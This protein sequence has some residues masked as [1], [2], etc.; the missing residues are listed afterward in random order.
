MDIF[1]YLWG[2]AAQEVE[3]QPNKFIKKREK[4]KKGNDYFMDDVGQQT[5]SWIHS[6]DFIILLLFHVVRFHFLTLF[7]GYHGNPSSSLHN[8]I[9]FNP[10]G[11]INLNPILSNSINHPVSV[12]PTFKST[13][14]SPT[15]YSIMNNY[16]SWIINNYLT[17][18]IRINS[19]N[20]NN[21]II[22]LIMDNNISLI[23]SN[24]SITFCR[25]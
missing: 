17:F 5:V 23:I 18:S 3:E 22:N 1:G 21:V 6:N 2:A 14:K 11:V 10:T 15:N 4:K 25:N 20:N 16:I 12:S 9:Q 7:H 19:N 13:S 24:N 8:S